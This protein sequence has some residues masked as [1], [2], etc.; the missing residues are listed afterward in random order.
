[1]KV[2]LK[3]EEKKLQE[4]TEKTDKFLKEL[5]IENEKAKKKA[6]EVGIVT[7]E[8]TEQRNKIMQER[9]TANKEL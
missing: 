8:C 3:E 9:E 7:E 1:M 6:T 5:E 4:A 2:A